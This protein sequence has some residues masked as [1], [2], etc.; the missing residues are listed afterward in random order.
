MM[1]SSDTKPHDLPNAAARMGKFIAGMARSPVSDPV[2]LLV[3]KRALLDCIASTLSGAREPVVK[4]LIAYSSGRLPAEAVVIGGA[5]LRL[6]LDAAALINGTMGHA[7]DYDDV[8]FTMWGHATAPVLPAVLAVGEQLNLSGAHFLAAFLAGLE[9]EMKLGAAVAPHHYGIGWHPTATIG[10]FGACAGAAAAARLTAEQSAVAICIAA[11]R[12]SSLRANF[13]SMTKALHVGFASRDGL[14]A[15]MLASRG[16]TSNPAAIDGSFGFVEVMAAGKSCLDDRLAH[17]GAPFDIVDPG[18]ALKYYPS[19]S[20]THVA[21]DTLLDLVNAEGIA[22]PSIK[23]IRCGVTKT[24]FDNLIYHSP[25]TG[26]Q[27]KFSMEFCLARAL[28][29]GRLA[30]GDFTDDSVSEAGTQAL[31]G[32]IEMVIDPL[33]A[34][35]DYVSAASIEVECADGSAIK[36]VS[37]SARGHTDR[38]LDDTQLR[39]KFDTCA[40]VAMSAHAGEELYEL[41]ERIELLPSVRPLAAA[42]AGPKR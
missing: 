41:I 9:V 27:G 25:R 3:V 12:S 29:N 38:P 22:P 17:L 10:V 42:L 11:S 31:M 28:E 37:R 2:V 15:A 6:P 30:L 18:L 35:G 24:V 40:R 39:Q 32:K 26:L 4:K 7:T 8:S 14:E 36:K 19:C 21:V 33:I 1:K 20:D 16:I 23:H 13:A 5:G 34:E